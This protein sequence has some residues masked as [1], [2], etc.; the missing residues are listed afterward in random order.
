MN[1]VKRSLV[2]EGIKNK[3]RALGE[4][5]ALKRVEISLLLIL[6]FSARL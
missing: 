2:R 6:D 3:V 4:A 1:F 5:K